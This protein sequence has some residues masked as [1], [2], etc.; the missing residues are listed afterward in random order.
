MSE[1]QRATSRVR[2]RRSAR[3]AGDQLR[4]EIITA[5]KEL[6]A[7]AG[8]AEDVSVRAVADAVGV[9]TPSIYL[10]F[11]DKDALMTAVVLDVL[12]EL[13][14]AMLAAAEGIE[15]PL[16]RLRAY[17]LAYI[18]FAIAHP[19][20][21]RLATMDPR[22]GHSKKEIDE[23]LAQAAFQHLFETASALVENGTFR[24]DDPLSLA[25]ELWTTAHGIAAL[26]IAKPDLPLGDRRLFADRT[27]CRAALGH[28][29]T[30]PE[31]W[32]TPGGPLRP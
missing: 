30:P 31:G 21:Y 32:P 19:E 6:L 28:T 13:D 7:R 18:E 8:R 9:T 16:W 4:A 22:P 15:D 24:D 14:E 27:L 25:F 3:G 1:R 23:M 26:L 20:H 17:A 29:L 10:H 5:T 12:R 11:A 2:R